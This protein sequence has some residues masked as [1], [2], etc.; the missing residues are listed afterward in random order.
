MGEQ[1][2]FPTTGVAVDAYLEQ[3]NVEW[4]D[5]EDDADAQQKGKP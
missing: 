3:H 5:W 4:H 1:H 2:F